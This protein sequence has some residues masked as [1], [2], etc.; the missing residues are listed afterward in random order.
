MTTIGNR[1]KNLRNEK[2][3]TQGE[4]AK[5]LGVTKPA[6]QKYEN[7]G[8]NNLKRETIQ[9]LCEFFGVPPVFFIYDELPANDPYPESFRTIYGEKLANMAWMFDRLN[10]TGRE[11]VIEYTGDIFK[12]GEYRK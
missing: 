4:L 8:I 3:M 9:K 6:V 5:V 2:G 11:K 1:I 7:G 12:I 10:Q